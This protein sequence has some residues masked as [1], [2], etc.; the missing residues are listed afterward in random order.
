MRN[1][2]NSSSLFFIAFS[3][4]PFAFCLLPLFAAQ[5]AT[6]ARSRSYADAYNQVSIV[7][8]QAAYNQQQQA[9]FLENPTE[10][11]PVRVAN[12][13]LATRIAR[14]DTS[15]GVE[16]GSLESCAA[17]YPGGNFA[18]D[19]P[20]VGIKAGQSSQ[21]TAIVEMRAIK[22]SED[23][24]IARVNVAAG[25]S[26]E[27]NIEKF[28][29]ASYL[30]AAYEITFPADKEPSMDD[31]I[32]TMN[33]EQAKNAGIKIAAGAVIGGLL[34]NAS[35]KNDLGNTGIVGTDKGKMQ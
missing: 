12:Q 21:C 7:Q 11:L 17:I 26:T 24:L 29:T 14:G 34:G 35:G 30:P 25:D 27:C 3:S 22:G 4:L 8:Q 18:W 13:D 32:A 2:K 31:V 1:I 28:P 6:P 16:M 15:A 10:N 23:I 19:K 33:K 20:T 5:I 9:A